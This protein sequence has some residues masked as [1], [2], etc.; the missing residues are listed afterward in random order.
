MFAVADLLSGAQLAKGASNS[1][2]IVD[3]N[4]KPQNYQ[5]LR[6]LLNA[7]DLFLLLRVVSF[8]LAR[9]RILIGTILKMKNKIKVVP[10]C[11]LPITCGATFCYLLIGGL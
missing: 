10:E 2:T 1:T 3:E 5:I 7:S 11:N 6:L 4:L 8:L 9:G